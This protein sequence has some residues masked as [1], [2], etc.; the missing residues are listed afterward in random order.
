MNKSMLSGTFDIIMELP[1]VNVLMNIVKAH[2]NFRVSMFSGTLLK[3]HGTFMFQCS[4][5]HFKITEH[6]R[7]NVL[8][9]IVKAPRNFHVSMFSGTF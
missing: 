3:H 4:Q 1:H 5:E 7:V 9:N 6:P 8:M 2:G